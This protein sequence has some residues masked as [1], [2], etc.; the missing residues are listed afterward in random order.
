MSNVLF[1][2]CNLNYLLFVLHKG[3]KKIRVPPQYHQKLTSQ[4]GG[5]PEQQGGHGLQKLHPE[6]QWLR[7]CQHYV[8]ALL[9]VG[10]PSRM[11]SF[12]ANGCRLKAVSHHPLLHGA[13]FGAASCGW[14]VLSLALVLQRPATVASSPG[15]GQGGAVHPSAPRRWP[16]QQGLPWRCLVSLFKAPLC[17][18]KTVP[19]WGVF[20]I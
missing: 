5:H 20:L 18:T 1:S 11:P 17:C 4:A 12:R 2:H 7:G 6:T 19:Y 8:E 13:G 16:G 14:A 10:I 15:V 9:G 3:K